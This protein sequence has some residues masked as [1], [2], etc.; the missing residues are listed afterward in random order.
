LEIR[1]GPNRQHDVTL[2]G[3]RGPALPYVAHALGP[4]T[5]AVVAAFSH[6]SRVAVATF[7]LSR[8]PRGR[9]GQPFTLAPR[10]LHQPSRTLRDRCVQPSLTRRDRPIQPPLARP[11]QTTPRPRTGRTYHPNQ[12]PL[13]TEPA[14]SM[15]TASASGLHRARTPQHQ[16]SPAPTS[17][18]S[19]NPPAQTPLRPGSG[20]IPKRPRPGHTPHQGSLSPCPRRSQPPHHRQTPTLLHRTHVLRQNPCTSAA[21]NVWWRPARDLSFC[22]TLARVP[23]L[24]GE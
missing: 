23:A 12:P 8:T 4:R 16:S 5:R 20:R 21:I 2:V 1:C 22:L 19:P 7:S 18:N 15:P 13:R 24:N 10:S 17:S 3:W 14:P 6:R 9:C 11:C